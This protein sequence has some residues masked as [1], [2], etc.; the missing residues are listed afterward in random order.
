[1]YAYIEVVGGGGDEKNFKSQFL[2]IDLFLLKPI[3]NLYH[4]F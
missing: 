1:M 3:N 2:S 4:R